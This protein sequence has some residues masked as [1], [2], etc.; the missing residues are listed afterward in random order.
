MSRQKLLRYG[1]GPNLSTT[2][3]S[4]CATL[5][6][7]TG[8]RQ[9]IGE[10]QEYDSELERIGQMADRELIALVQCGECPH[11]SHLVDPRLG[12]YDCPLC[13]EMVL[14]GQYHP[15][16]ADELAATDDEPPFLPWHYYEPTD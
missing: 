12:V 4:L 9:T 6:L 7:L 14:A 15:A 10:R 1:L 3:G 13:G 2:I 5:S 11:P 16:R 8:L